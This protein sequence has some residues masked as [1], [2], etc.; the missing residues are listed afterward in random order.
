MRPLRTSAPA[1]LSAA[2]LLS[3]CSSGSDGAGGPTTP[4]ATVTTT[5]TPSSTV[6]VPSGVA[7]TAQGSTLAFGEPAR[8]IFESRRKRGTVLKLNVRSV[9]RGRLEDFGGFILDDRY[10]QKASY[11]YAAVTVTNIG[12]GDVGGV[13]VPLWGVD[14]SNTLL[15][16]VAFTTRFA[17]C[18]TRRLPARFPPGAT[19]TTCL[20]FLSP[21]KGG[22]S[23]VSYR[24]SQQY[25][26]VTWTGRVRP[27]SKG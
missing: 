7:L 11:Y 3:G 16:P 2:L 20:V 25:D 13:A 15:P 19:L 22:L 8:V 24:P 27:A 18:P 1:L 6:G 26:P 9:R 5:R 10:K 14:R 23:G 4:S 12:R 17:P 21:G